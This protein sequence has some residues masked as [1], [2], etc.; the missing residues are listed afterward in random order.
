MYIFK[1]HSQEHAIQKCF[2]L[3]VCICSTFRDEQRPHRLFWD[4]E[5]FSLDFYFLFFFYFF[6]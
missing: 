5:P 1:M 6:F 2:G 4:M 3:C